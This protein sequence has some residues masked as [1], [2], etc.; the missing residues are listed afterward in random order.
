MGSSRPLAFLTIQRDPIMKA[1][2]LQRYVTALLG[3]LTLAS[4]ALGQEQSKATT[5]DLSSL[6]EAYETARHSVAPVG[7]QFKAYNPR[8]AWH[9]HFDNRGFL[10]RPETG[11]WSWGL[12]LQS[13]GFEGE[14]Q[15][16]SDFACASAEQG[17]VQYQWDD[18]L[19]E[20]YINDSRGLEH[21]F[22]LRERPQQVTGSD[23]QTKLTLTLAVRGSLTPNVHANGRSV[24]FTTEAGVSALNY[25][26]L[27]VFDVNG[28]K[29][30]ASF[31]RLNDQL[32]LHI[33][34]RGAQYPLTIDPIAQQAYLKASN[35]GAGD[36]FGHAV[37]ID[38]NT[39]IIGAP[40]EASNATGVNGDQ[41]NNDFALAGAAYVFVSTLT[42]WEQQAYLKASN[43][44][45]GDRF[46]ISVSL[47]GDTA[48]IGAQGEAGPSTGVNGPESSDAASKA[49]AAYIFVRSGITWSQQAYIKASNTGVEDAF[50]HA[51]DI[52]G[53]L[54]VVGALREASPAMGVDGDQAPN[55]AIGAGAA[56]VFGRTGTTWAQQ[57]YLKASNANGADFFGV[58]VSVSGDTIVVGARSEDSGAPGGNGNPMI[59]TNGSGAAYVFKQTGTTWV[60]EALLKASYPESGDQFGSGVS[61]SGN[62]LIVGARQERSG[63]T[64]V[65][66]DESDNSVDSAG[67][68]YIFIRSGSNWSQ[69]AYLKA[70]DP[71]ISDRFGWRV[72]LHGD[73]AIVGCPFESSDASGIHGDPFNDNSL[74]SGAAHLFRRFGT[75][76]IPE[77]YLKASNSGPS[78]QFGFGVAIGSDAAIVGATS[79]DSNATGVGGDQS[80]DSL[81]FAG[82]AYVF[83][84]E[85]MP[86][87]DFCNGDGGNQAGCTNCPC[88]N[89]SP[90][91][92]IGGCLNSV[93]GSARLAATGSPSISL[94]HGS[95][96]DLRFSMTSAPSTVLTVLYSGSTLAP[97]GM[98]NPCLGMQSGV[99][100]EFF[101]GIRCAVMNLRRHGNRQT[102]ANGEIGIASNTWGGANNPGAGIGVLGG[103]VA[104][105]TRYFQGQYRED[106][107]AVCM[108]G[109][110]TTQ[111]IEVTFAP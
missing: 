13:Y 111:A 80:D 8:Q 57:A 21:G 97:T 33:D 34:E 18:N 95:S 98:N 101:D 64:G 73:R 104:G 37:T 106:S 93:G 90:A 29:L 105:Q 4:A 15:R 83:D 41:G 75:T 22:T 74:N 63:A 47:S 59:P 52:S 65:N 68:A 60:E 25:S 7:D 20:W 3:S 23:D 102:D 5:R 17:R 110:N 44:G 70:S 77:A 48:V 28:D 9:T 50:G 62:T 71:G 92:T 43:T 66:G 99:Q 11:A 46:G 94:P 16:V 51:V 82:A 58:S 27:T 42:G 10:V 32:I 14:E 19:T 24:S 91:G 107:M 79:E 61:I 49:G 78:D 86:Y 96:A 2:R 1:P 56:Y 81:S 76:W 85:A 100:S 30:T 35:T 12:E 39:A 36:N 69:E 54:V 26:G 6:H 103:F 84:L 109:L 67:A 38:G 55:T 88:N 31:T 45:A 53:D 89:N 72:S 87:A 40:S 108:R